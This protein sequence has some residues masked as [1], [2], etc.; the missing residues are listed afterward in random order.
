MTFR[1]TV[2][3]YYKLTKPGIIRGNVMTA[4][5]GFFFASYGNYDW[6]LLLWL[7]VG[8]SLII[9]SAC[10]L[11]N[12]IDRDIDKRMERTKNRALVT[13]SIRTAHAMIYASVLGV[14]GYSLLFVHTNLITTVIGFVGMFFYIVLY[15]YY[16]RRSVHGTLI[17]GVSGSTSLVAG[18]CAVIG[19][20]DWIALVLFIIMALWQMPHFYAIGLYRKKDYEEAGLPIFPVV[21][22]VT[23]TKKHILWYIIAFSL[24]AILLAFA[25]T[26]GVTYIA[27][28]IIVCTLWLRLAIKGLTAK[29][30]IKYG[31]QIFGQSLVVLL[32]FSIA[33]S[34]TYYLP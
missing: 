30:T 33:I 19:H 10:V 2:Y 25:P 14:I 28:M 31:H 5:A 11:N 9:A 1:D 21:Y 7:V 4:I 8:I 22:G 26:V 3:E 18:Y 29:D 13:G 24:S 20:F 6:I 16:K 34:L 23:K 12:Y 32:V 17:G 27:S 15:G